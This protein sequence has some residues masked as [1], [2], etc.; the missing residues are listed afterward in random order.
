[1]RGAKNHVLHQGIY[2]ASIFGAPIQK[3][4]ASSRKLLYRRH[5]TFRLLFTTDQAVNHCNGK[6]SNYFST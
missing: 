3:F 6:N 4:P 5:K 1:M 2:P